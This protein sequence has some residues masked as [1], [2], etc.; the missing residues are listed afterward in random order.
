MSF[1]I[2][3]EVCLVFLQL[4]TTFGGMCML[5]QHR[6]GARFCTRGGV[7]KVLFR[8]KFFGIGKNRD[9]KAGEPASAGQHM[10]PL[11]TF[12]F[13]HKVFAACKPIAYTALLCLGLN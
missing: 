7:L 13:S 10:P 8:Y 1:Y 9:T 2:H 6:G 11:Q 4:N 3:V 12:R 5:A